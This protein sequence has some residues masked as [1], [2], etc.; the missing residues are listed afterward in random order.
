MKDYRSTYN[1]CS[2]LEGGLAFVSGHGAY[3]HIDF[4]ETRITNMYAY[5]GAIFFV[6][7]G[8]TVQMNRGINIRYT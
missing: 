4:P 5:K 1:K 7:K 8:G 3:L 2:A 6:E